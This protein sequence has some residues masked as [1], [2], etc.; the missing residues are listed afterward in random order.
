[1]VGCGG[2]CGTGCTA[3]RG[4]AGTPPGTAPLAAWRPVVE[5]VLGPAPPIAALART[6][7]GPLRP[8]PPRRTRHD[9]RNP[10]AVLLIRPR[11]HA[12][13]LPGQGPLS[14]YR[15][16]RGVVDLRPPGGGPRRAP[17]GG[18]Q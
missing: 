12:C 17:G 9:P 11:G 18:C 2:R 16:R 8:G 3:R 6:P 7:P 14:G 15:R 1:D 13:L 4:R 10:R 5:F